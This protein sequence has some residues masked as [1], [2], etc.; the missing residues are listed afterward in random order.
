[1]ELIGSV[2]VTSGFKNV[3]HL[4]DE[5]LPT[6]SKTDDLFRATS[7][8]L[9]ALF[10]AAGSVGIDV[11]ELIG[12]SLKITISLKPTTTDEEEYLTFKS[13]E[14]TSDHDGKKCTCGGT[15][16]EE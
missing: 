5:E 14:A 8:D 11:R 2:Q 13:L 15:C 12:E 6:G 7:D 9:A 4:L 16:H 10:Q 1:M 3:L